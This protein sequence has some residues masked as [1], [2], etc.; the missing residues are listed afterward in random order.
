M[1]RLRH[2]FLE[3]IVEYRTGSRLEL[4]SKTPLDLRTEFQLPGTASLVDDEIV[5]HFQSRCAGIHTARIFA[6]TRELCRPIAFRVTGNGTVESIPTNRPVAFSDPTEPSLPPPPR[7][8]AS[9]HS[10]NAPQSQAGSPPRSP[11]SAAGSGGGSLSTYHHAAT[12]PYSDAGVLPTESSRLPP[13]RRGSPHYET[14]SVASHPRS[15]HGSFSGDLISSTPGVYS[16]S[17]LYT[18]KQKGMSI[19]VGL[20]FIDHASVITAE[21]LK[22]IKRGVTDKV[23][24]QL[25]KKIR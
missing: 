21:A 13:H 20:K 8:S 7:L 11:A 23:A 18:M 14:A 24:K 19:E 16:F 6:H 5:I 9:Q 15:T 10:V 25:G 1:Q 2:S 4:Q 3:C 17:D 12:P 22:L